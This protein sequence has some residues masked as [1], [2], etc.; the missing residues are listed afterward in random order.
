MP[1]LIALLLAPMADAPPEKIALA[2]EERALLARV[3]EERK[4]EGLGALRPH[5]KL[6]ES[7]RAHSKNMA[8]QDKLA[9]VLDGKTPLERLKDSGYKFRTM[10]E[11][12]AAG[13]RTA[14]EAMDTWMESEL[15]RANILNGGFTEVGFGVAATKDGKR[16]WTQVF[17]APPKR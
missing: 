13:Q 14:S 4:K 1:A 5:P 8:A 3:N 16:Y 2:A 17:A 11:N 10:G 7:A 12:V 9:H 15:H 6:F